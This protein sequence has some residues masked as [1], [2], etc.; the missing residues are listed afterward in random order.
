M[1]DEIKKYLFDIQISYPLIAPCKKQDLNFEKY[2]DTS[3]KVNKKYYFC[4]KLA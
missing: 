1:N 4:I 3:G 2:S